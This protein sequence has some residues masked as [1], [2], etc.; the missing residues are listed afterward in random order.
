M[1]RE[2]DGLQERCLDGY[3]SKFS[4]R[5]NSESSE[6]C[7]FHGESSEMGSLNGREQCTYQVMSGES[8]GLRG[9]TSIPCALSNETASAVNIAARLR[10][11]SGSLP[12]C[13]SC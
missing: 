5:M 8:R 3:S 7:G 12:N 1:E 11:L 13:K 4:I 6:L 10:G 2:C 9:E